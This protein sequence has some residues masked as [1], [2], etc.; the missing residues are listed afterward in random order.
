M[1]RVAV[2]LAAALGLAGLARGADLPAQ[3]PDEQPARTNCFA[4]FW[5]WLAA[6]PA[7]CHLSYAGVSLY[8]VLD[9]NAAYLNQGLGFNPSEY[10]ISYGIVRG[11]HQS[12]FLAGFNGLSASVIGLQMHENLAPLGLQG[13][14]LM[15]VVEAGVNPYSGILDNGPRSL[16]DNNPRPA[17]RSPWQNYNGDSSRAGQW[18]NSQ[19]FL[20]VSHAG[21]G[22]LTFGRTNSLAS[23]VTSTYDP[24]AS[25][26]FSLIG[27]SSSVAGFGATET[28]RPN[29][30]F[31]YRVNYGNFRAAA[32]VQL[33]GYGVGNGSNGQYQGQ[34]GADFGPLSLDGVM[35]WTKDAVSLSGFAG[36]N[37]AQAP[38]GQYEVFVNNQYFNPNNVLKATL[39]NDFGAE[40]AAKYKWDRMTLYGGYIY[41]RVMNPSDSYLTGFPTIAA[42]I[43]VPPGYWNGGGAYVNSAVNASNYNYHKVLQTVWT[44]FKWSVYSNLTIA[45]GFYYQNQN[46]FNFVVASSG[47]TTPAACTGT[48][49]HISSSKCAGSRDGVSI[50]LDYQP[51]K[52]VDIYGGVMVENVYGGLA[53][54]FFTTASAYNLV[55]RTTYT[56]NT[57][58]TRNYDPT[59]GV[60][61][62]F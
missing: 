26:A 59:V 47:V 38:N 10:K 12:E 35:N 48:G 23:G 16:T 50:L 22:S 61:I 34:L 24:L 20:G 51:F 49:P 41:A 3:K 11:A 13:W 56:V 25:N 5:D 54:G 4:S 18:D 30:A 31:T 44:G 36:S 52:R 46:N 32:Q 21:Y 6:S 15:G 55:T 33:G 39:S 62:R 57:A 28:V 14:S 58:R 8:G 9:L 45:M 27:F 7:D 42:G 29:T 2:V 60:R 43:F 19:G 17:N 37:I 40:L 53:N 1:K